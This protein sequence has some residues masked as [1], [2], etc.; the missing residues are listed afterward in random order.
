[1]DLAHGAEAHAVVIVGEETQAVPGGHVAPVTRTFLDQRP[2]IVGPELQRRRAFTVR[3]V[4]LAHCFP[5]APN[6]QAEA[7]PCGVQ[8]LPDHP[9][10]WGEGKGLRKPA[11]EADTNRLCSQLLW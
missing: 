7:N 11:R 2:G 9:G 4:A 10:F 8:E 6:G 3:A 5:F 1:E